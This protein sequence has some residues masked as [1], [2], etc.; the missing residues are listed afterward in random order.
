MG[1]NSYHNEGSFPEDM[2]FSD[3]VTREDRPTNLELLAQDEFWW[4][5]DFRNKRVRLKNMT[6]EHRE[7]LEGWLRRHAPKFK[8]DFEEELLREANSSHSDVVVDAIRAQWKASTQRTADEWIDDRPLMIKLQKQLIKAAR[9]HRRDWVRSL[10]A[11]HPL[12]GKARRMQVVG[13]EGPDIW[14]GVAHGVI[15]RATLIDAPPLWVYPYEDQH[16][17]G[18]MLIDKR[19]DVY[20]SRFRTK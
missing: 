9:R 13:A 2:I 7:N 11:T 6:V 18:V 4:P 14:I 19:G 5:N 10:K 16:Q 20:A 15:V 17:I 12:R 1:D 3:D 8:R